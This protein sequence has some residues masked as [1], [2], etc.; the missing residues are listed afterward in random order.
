MGISRK[1]RLYGLGIVKCVA[2]IPMGENIT[3]LDVEQLQ[4]T[5]EM[6]A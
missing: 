6:L 2:P 4:Q 3:I 1:K 5:M